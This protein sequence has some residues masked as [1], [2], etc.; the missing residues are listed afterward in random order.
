MIQI[1]EECKDGKIRGTISAKQ[2]LHRSQVFGSRTVLFMHLEPSTIM[3][4]TLL[5]RECVSSKSRGVPA[6]STHGA[7]ARIAENSVMRIAPL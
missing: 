7:L 1:A 5:T 6:S 2:V 4:P 3:F